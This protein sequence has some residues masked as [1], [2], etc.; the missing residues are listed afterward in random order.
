VVYITEDCTELVWITLVFYAEILDSF[1]NF[2]LNIGG[3]FILSMISTRDF[4]Y[5]VDFG[6]SMSL[7]GIVFFDREDAS[8]REGT[9]YYEER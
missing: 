2:E 5:I 7:V 1:T 6:I 8:D 3:R 9:V 4:V